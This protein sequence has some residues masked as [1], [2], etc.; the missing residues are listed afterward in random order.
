MTVRQLI[1]Y[2]IFPLLVLLWLGTTID[3]MIDVYE[4]YNTYIIFN[5][6]PTS[7]IVGSGR[8]VSAGIFHIVAI[9]CL[10]GLLIHFIATNWDKRVL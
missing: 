8:I 7:K 6:P 2:I 3:T 4:A 1:L 5:V 9:L 10:V